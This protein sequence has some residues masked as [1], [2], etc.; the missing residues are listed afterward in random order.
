MAQRH[1]LNSFIT[2]HVIAGNCLGGLS[3]FSKWL[4]AVECSRNGP[5]EKQ[6]IFDASYDHRLDSNGKDSDTH[7]ATLKL[8]HQLLWSKP[9]PDGTL[10]DLQLE[11]AK[12]LMHQSHLGSF[13]LSSDTIS[14][15]LR[16]QKRMKWL[17]EQIAE[18]ELD[19]F[20]YMS[21]VVGSKLLF[22]GNRIAGQSTINAARGFNSKIN[23]RF[24]LTLECI[25]LHY[26]GQTSPL[27]EPLRRYSAFFSLFIDF[28]S[29]VQFFLLQDLVNKNCTQV[30]FF[31]PH[32]GSFNSSPRPNS[33]ES[34]MTYKANTVVFI[35][36]RNQRMSQWVL[37]NS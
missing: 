23:D 33:L 10:F 13:H 19:H 2:P 29:Y 35:N 3:S 14:H 6:M 34:Y 37:D 9:L 21:S 18:E 16:A 27:S 17:I 11:S 1:H 5:K 22:P 31:L 28:S 12:Y 8:Q 30:R 15:S 7:S 36:A 20:Q 26:L 4:S 24:D 32:D 25:R